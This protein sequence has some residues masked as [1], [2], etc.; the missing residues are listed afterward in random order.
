VR[1]L[2]SKGVPQAPVNDITLRDCDFKG[3]TQ[4]SIM[5]YTKEV[6]LEKVR[7]NQKLVREL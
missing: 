3:V 6:R 5:K 7:V 1:A 4:P 2:D